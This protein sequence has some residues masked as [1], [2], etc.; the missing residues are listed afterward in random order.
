[1]VKDEELD[2]DLSILKD[3]CICAHSTLKILKT[4][5]FKISA[6]LK[7]SINN[8]MCHPGFVYD[9]CVQ[10]GVVFRCGFGAVLAEQIDNGVWDPVMFV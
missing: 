9:A 3:L 5:F 7:K 4:R 2:V 1:M 8:V 10:P 6:F